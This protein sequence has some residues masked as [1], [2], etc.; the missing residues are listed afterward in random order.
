MCKNL[1]RDFWRLREI[2]LEISSPR[3]F[4]NAANSLQEPPTY[5]G[6]FTSPT[7]GISFICFRGNPHEP[8]ARNL[9]QE[10]SAS[11]G[12]YTAEK[13]GILPKTGVTAGGAG[14]MQ[15]Q[16]GSHPLEEAHKE[17]LEILN[18]VG[19]VRFDS[20]SVAIALRSAGAPSALV[21]EIPLRGAKPFFPSRPSGR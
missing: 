7:T 20:P 17:T 2:C 5:N 3:E 12:F 4:P 10:T 18:P 15:A 1:P 16:T 6:A 14:G 11:P 13:R 8:R 9:T 19:C 21:F